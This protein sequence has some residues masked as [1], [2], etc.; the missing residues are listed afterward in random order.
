M[1]RIHNTVRAI[2]TVLRN[3]EDFTTTTKSL[4]TGKMDRD[5]VPR[6][7]RM[8]ANAKQ[9]SRASSTQPER[10]DRER[11]KLNDHLS[12]LILSQREMRRNF[13]DEGVDPKQ[14]KLK[15]MRGQPY[16]ITEFLELQVPK[17]S[18]YQDGLYRKFPKDIAKIVDDER[19]SCGM[20][21]VSP[22]PLTML[23]RSLRL[24]KFSK[25]LS[26][27]RNKEFYYTGDSWNVMH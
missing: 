7:D 23:K 1:K 18:S 10:L 3:Q 26:E 5:P 22:D 24:Q 20:G 8:I 2:H 13:H 9:I 15:F 4:F 21:G 11:Q 17:K 14:I 27:A 6:M 25:D 12:K 16:N 19:N